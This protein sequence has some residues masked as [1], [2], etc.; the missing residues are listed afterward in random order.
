MT[1]SPRRSASGRPARPTGASCTV[2]TRRAPVR[3]AARMP[4][5]AGPG[6]RAWTRSMPCC[7]IARA[8]RPALRQLPKPGLRRA[9]GAGAWRPPRR[10]RARAGRRPTRPPTASRSRAGGARCRR[11]C[12]RL[13]GSSSGSSCS[14]AGGRRRAGV[15]PVATGAQQAARNSGACVAAADD[16]PSSHANGL[17][18][19][20]E[21][22]Q[23]SQT[24]ANMQTAPRHL[25]LNES[26]VAG[27]RRVRRAAAPTVLFLTGFRS[28]MT[29][30][31]A[32]HLERHCARRG[33]G[34][35]A[36]R[37]SR[38]RRVRRA[39]S[40]TAASA[41]GARTRWR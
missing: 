10:A 3:R 19:S 35:P 13:V 24:H 16:Q 39:G 32:L 31:K 15:R 30:A 8:S 26:P 9:A 4:L 7:R 37:L 34:L 21:S 27:L 5:A 23:A 25:N 22:R 1:R 18:G 14:T 20:L 41:T 12:G 6:A 36:L 33:P 29:G 28:D 11:C 40:R 17:R 38:P 2:V